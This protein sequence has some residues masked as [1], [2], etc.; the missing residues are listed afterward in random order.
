[1]LGRESEAAMTPKS[2]L[3][4]S[5]LLE[6]EFAQLHGQPKCSQGLRRAAKP[7]GAT[8]TSVLRLFLSAQFLAVASEKCMSWVR[9]IRTGACVKT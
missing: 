3:L 2:Q 5:Q 7:P 1:M 6:V 8:I 4:S 9:M